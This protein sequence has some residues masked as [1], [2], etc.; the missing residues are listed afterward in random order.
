LPLFFE[1]ATVPAGI[2]TNVRGKYMMTASPGRWSV[3][4]RQLHLLICLSLAAV[5][6]AV[7]WNVQFHDFILYDDLPYVVL[8]PHVQSGLTGGSIFWAV[9]TMEMSNWHPL[10]WLSLM[11][12]YDLFRLNPVG[13][14]WTNLLIHIAGT[15]L[16]FSV[17]KRMTEDIW[18]SALVAALFAIH[19]LHVESVAWI[20]ERKD[21]LSAFFWFLTMGTYVRYTERPGTGNYLL[22]IAAFSLGL[23]AKPMLVT[24]PFVLLLLD[25]WPLRRLPVPFTRS[26]KTLPDAVGSRGVTWLHALR[27]KLPFFFLVALSSVVTYLAQ[28]NW[29]AMP[30]LEALPL[31]TRMANALIAY[32]QYIVKMVWPAD[33]AFFYP[34]AAWWS[35]W[36][37]S[38][39]VLLLAGMT[40]LTM[41]IVERRPYLAVG[42]FWYLGTLVPVIG[43]VQI[44]SQAMADRYTY[45]PLIGLFIMIAWGV[46]SL[47]AKWR[48]RKR[49][50]SGL[51]V[52]I[53]S[54]LAVCSWQQVQHWK[55]SVTLFERALTVTAR[56]YLAHNNLGV[57]LFYEGRME[58]A[59]SQYA[60]SLRIKP[61]LADARNNIGVA[62]AAQGK[63]DEAV[64]HYREALH[65]RPDDAGIHNNIG[66]A[67]AAQGK[68]DAAID[69]YTQALRIRPDHEKARANLAA[70]LAGRE[71]P[72][73]TAD[74]VNDAQG[75]ALRGPADGA[76][77]D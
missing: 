76:R 69:H 61:N 48:F 13:Y 55:N 15:I 41:R 14:H 26:N 75:G 10:T 20:S 9:T 28:M 65:I 6:L 7:F 67:L 3:T 59:I 47:M 39:A 2:L 34:Y 23:S 17:L 57:A 71:E 31:E 52:A 19:P 38:G 66:V 51:S 37:V 27:E 24:L 45:I 16:L 50:L 30:S 44:G 40:I 63:Y 4:D 62:L 77:Q 49:F 1:T 25:I 72:R 54:V 33:L 73:K 11:L 29:K 8:N 18:K 68:I 42:W 53:L 22:V 64:R 70:A 5:T 43:I 46:P 58:E 12:D 35:L 56:N 21:V 36:M 32:V 60:A 74:L